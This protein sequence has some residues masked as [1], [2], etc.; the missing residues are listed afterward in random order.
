[1]AL[2]LQIEVL[3]KKKDGIKIYGL[4]IACDW[5]ES[6]ETTKVKILGNNEEE[7]EVYENDA[8]KELIRY[9]RSWVYL[10]GQL[11]T[12]S[13]FKVIDIEKISQQKI[14]GSL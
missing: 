8:G 4:V 14:G 1:M 2:L 7:Y 11:L 9:E 10:T 3:M 5:N 12:F 13:S 6:G